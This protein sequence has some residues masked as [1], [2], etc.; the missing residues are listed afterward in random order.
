[1]PI[2]KGFSRVGGSAIAMLPVIIAPIAAARNA[3]R[4]ELMIDP[5]VVD[6]RLMNPRNPTLDYTAAGGTIAICLGTA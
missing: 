5:P 3:R 1:M 6:A 4:L 2:R